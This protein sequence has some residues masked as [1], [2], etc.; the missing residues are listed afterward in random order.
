MAANTP[1]SFTGTG[2]EITAGLNYFLA[3]LPRQKATVTA[4]K[5]AIM[6]NDLAAAKVTYTQSRPMYE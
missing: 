5:E 4:L 2:P 1:A 3:L 6:S